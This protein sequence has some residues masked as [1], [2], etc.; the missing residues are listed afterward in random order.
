[1]ADHNGVYEMLHKN[2]DRDMVFSCGFSPDSRRIACGTESGAVLIVGEPS[3][4]AG[5]Q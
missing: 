2:T 5:A 3:R 4:A 1:L